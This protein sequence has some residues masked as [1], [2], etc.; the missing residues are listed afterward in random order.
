LIRAR[1]RQSKLKVEQAVEW[2][3]QMRAGR[4]YRLRS[5]LL[6]QAPTE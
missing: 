2:R 1:G 6:S 3:I 5:V 4:I